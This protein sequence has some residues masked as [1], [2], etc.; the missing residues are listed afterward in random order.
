[1]EEVKKYLFCDTDMLV[2]KIWCE[3]KFGKCH[4][5]ILDKLESKTY[6]LHLLCN[7][8]IPWEPDPLRENPDDRER[9]FDLYKKELTD[10]GYPFAIIDGMGMERL[11]RA[12]TI[13]ENT[14]FFPNSKQTQNSKLIK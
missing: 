5:W 8:D 2:C 12:I 4:N 1:M 9:L 3:E 10:T 11:E 6:D 7:T 14:K 13:I